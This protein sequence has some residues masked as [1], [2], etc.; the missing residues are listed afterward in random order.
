MTAKRLQQLQVPVGWN[1]EIAPGVYHM[2][3][4]C[5]EGFER[6]RPGQFVMV[7]LTRGLAPLLRRPFSIHRKTEKGGRI[8]GIELLYKVVGEGTRMMADICAGD[9]VDVVGPLGSG[10]Q[11]GPEVKRVALAAGGMGVAPLVFLAETLAAQGL[12]P[13][14]VSVFLGAGSQDDLLCTDRFRALG[15][16]VHLTTDDGSAGQQCLVTQPLERAI[17]S[18][19]P[20]LVCACGPMAMLACVAGLAQRFAVPAQVSIEALMACGLGACLGCA[21]P[22]PS[23]GAGF[24]HACLDGPVFDAQQLDL[25]GRFLH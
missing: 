20:D 4:T 19:P 23:S 10:F 11:V 2:G 14:N 7:R 3:L 16:G 9:R 21:V 8:A 1:R 5:P 25:A 6:A 24:L 22:R 12:A 18:L 17:Q 15:M 13:E